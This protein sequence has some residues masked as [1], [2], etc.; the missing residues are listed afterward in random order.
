MDFLKI[1]KCLKFV[2]L[3]HKETIEVRDNNFF[4]KKLCPTFIEY[5]YLCPCQQGRE[6]LL[7]SLICVDASQYELHLFYLCVDVCGMHVPQPN[8]EGQKITCKSQFSFSTVWGLETEL[9]VLDSE[10]GTFTK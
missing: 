9:R 10:A 3:K 1:Q 8:Y 2:L 4:S 6:K 7:S 5:L